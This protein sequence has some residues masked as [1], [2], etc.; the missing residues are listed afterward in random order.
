[1]DLAFLGLDV[2]KDNVHAVLLDGERKRRL[3]FDNNADGFAKLVSWLEKLRARSVHACMEATGSYSEALA[4][5]LSGKVW[6]VSVVNPRKMK[7]YAIGCGAPT[8]SDPYDA[9]VIADYCRTQQ[10]REWKPPAPERLALRAL[11]R[12]REDLVE[13]VAAEKCRAADPGLTGR[14]RASI[15]AHMA[16]LE[17]AIK[18]L[19]AEIGDVIANDPEMAKM[20]KLLLTIPGVGETTVAIWIAE[21]GDCADF[22][23]AREVAAFLG[24]TPRHHTS[25]TS[26]WRRPRLSKAGNPLVRKALYFPAMSA[27]RHCPHLA[28][29]RQRKLREN[30]PRAVIIGAVMRKLAHTIFGV[31]RSGM[32]YDPSIPLRWT[33]TP[34]HSI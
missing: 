28:D 11:V 30:K 29:F 24:L 16:Y 9:A 2:S 33:L 21:L 20:R 17:Q 27:A 19:D 31:L 32:P 26:V 4:L 6:R 25:G 12:R 23:N 15:Q 1:M 34:Q 10:P 3:E 13:M 18:E 5:F 14:S 7:H 8:K 22:R